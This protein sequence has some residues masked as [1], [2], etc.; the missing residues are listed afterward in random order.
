VYDPGGTFAKVNWPVAFVV[1]TATCVVPLMS[2]TVASAI[3]CPAGFATVPWIVPLVA[4][5]VMTTVS[6]SVL[7]E[8]SVTVSVTVYVPGV[9]NV[10]EGLAPVSVTGPP[11][12][13]VHEY[14][15]IPPGSDEPV[16]SNVTVA[17]SSTVR[18]GPAYATGGVV[19][20]TKNPPDATAA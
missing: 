1:V 4:I 6:V 7:P 18:S 5:T 19:S 20:R 12:L 9:L 16:P 8:A 3:G 15:V 10:C 17:P 13:K 2:R 11:S 14:E